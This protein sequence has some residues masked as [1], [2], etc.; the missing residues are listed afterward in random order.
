MTGLLHRCCALGPVCACDLCAW[1]KMEPGWGGGEGVSFSTWTSSN[2]LSYRKPAHSCTQNKM[3]KEDKPQ[4][5]SHKMQKSYLHQQPK[6][7][8][9]PRNAVT[10][11]LNYKVRDVRLTRKPWMHYCPVLVLKVCPGKCDQRFPQKRRRGR[12]QR[13]GLRER[14]LLDFLK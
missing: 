12:P 9:K 6:K 7:P 2:S 3:E 14:E 4:M 8:R 13:F 11:R 10:H 1:L 5:T